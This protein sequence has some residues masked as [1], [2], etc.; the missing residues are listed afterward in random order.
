MST[1]T[2]S[3]TIEK[4]VNVDPLWYDEHWFREL[5]DEGLSEEDA[6][7]EMI[8]VGW[9]E[10]WTSLSQEILGGDADE[11]VKSVK[12]VKLVKLSNSEGEDG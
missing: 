10:D 7:R 6:L 1:Y 5:L 2:I 4:T 11:F 9:Q 12:S 3:L 8:H